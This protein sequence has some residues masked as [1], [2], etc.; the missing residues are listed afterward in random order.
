[1]ICLCRAVAVHKGIQ[2][3]ENRNPWLLKRVGTVRA[4][5]RNSDGSQGI[6]GGFAAQAVHDD[7][8]PQLAMS[9]SI[10]AAS[11]RTIGYLQVQ[12]RCHLPAIE[13]AA[14][15]RSLGVVQH[16]RSVFCLLAPALRFFA[17]V[18]VSFVLCSDDY[19][20]T[21]TVERG[22]ISRLSGAMLHQKCASLK[23]IEFCHRRRMG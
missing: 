16:S 6:V 10:Y 15:Q 12:S 4:D 5:D 7:Y 22:R 8:C 3:R 9:I 2:R 19:H 1:M 17:M 21:K 23:R 18:I 11:W 13:M 14:Q 20:E